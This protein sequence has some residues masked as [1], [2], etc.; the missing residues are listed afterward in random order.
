MFHLGR[1]RNLL[2]PA[3]VLALAGSLAPGQTRPP[4][5]SQ[6]SPAAAASS[7]PN[8]LA[9]AEK[10][11]CKENLPTLRR[12]MRSL[13]DKDMQFR[14][15][16][17]TARCAMGT[18]D[19]NV[20]IE[21]LLLL[22]TQF[23]QDPEVLY[24]SAQLFSMLGNQAAQELV[25]TAPDSYQVAKLNAEALESQQRWDEAEA[26]YRKSSSST[27]NYRTFI[28]ASRAFFSTDPLLRRPP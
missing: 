20:A 24:T 2:A 28:S 12:A 5:N 7:V 10:G 15:G 23:P 17:A 26:A 4:A 3:L 19:S 6:S 25:K 27:P 22:R 11:H 8:A 18:G 16:M 9:Q 14:V 13:P 1:F 21:A